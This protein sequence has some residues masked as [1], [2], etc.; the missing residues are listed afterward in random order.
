VLGFGINQKPIYVALWA[1][2][3]YRNPT[4]ND[5]RLAINLRVVYVL[6]RTVSKLLQIIGQIFALDGGYLSLTR[7]PELTTTKF[8]LKKL[9][10][11]LCRT[12]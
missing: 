6:S 12:V 2:D 7:T 3:W 8:G 5:M 10:T 9:E 1:F 4:L 11:S